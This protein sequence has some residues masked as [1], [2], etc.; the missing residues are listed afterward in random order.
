MRGRPKTA[1][2]SK[3]TRHVKSFFH[4]LVR[5]PWGSRHIG[6]DTSL[7]RNEGSHIN[8]VPLRVVLNHFLAPRAP[9]GAVCGGGTGATTRREEIGRRGKGGDESF[10]FSPFK[11]P[12]RWRR[13]IRGQKNRK[14]TAE[15]ESTVVV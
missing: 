9:R 13:L 8:H 1:S 4:T 7:L 11:F 6:G 10:E 2:R 5:S 12:S 14:T 3:S 15:V